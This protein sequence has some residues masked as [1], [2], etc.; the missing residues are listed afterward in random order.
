[1]GGE[2]DSDPP[3]R[4]SPFI[5]VKGVLHVML[6]Y[7]FWGEDLIMGLPGVVRTG[8]TLPLD[9]VLK[10]APSAM[11]TMVLDGL[12]FVLFFSI[13]YFG[14]RLCKVDPVFLCL[15][16]RSQQ[17]SVE[18]VVDGPG[19]RKL[20]LISYCEIRLLIAKGP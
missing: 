19:Q 8:V 9:Q 7:Q 4:P 12:N 11:M 15:A 18:H 13:N 5:L 10:L 3:T 2:V 6:P 16:I 20:E 14:W 17:A 1:M